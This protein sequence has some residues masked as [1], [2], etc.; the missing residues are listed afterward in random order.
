M[1]GWALVHLSVEIRL[2]TR[3][4]QSLRCQVPSPQ[5][6]ELK[7]CRKSP[8]TCCLKP[9]ITDACLQHELVMASRG[10]L[11]QH[12]SPFIEGLSRD[13]GPG[14]LKSAGS[15]PSRGWGLSPG[16]FEGWQ[17]S[18]KEVP[19]PRLKVWY[20]HSILRRH[21]AYHGSVVQKKSNHN[22]ET[23]SEA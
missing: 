9:T 11:I 4:R 12:A 22:L 6:P 16:T 5:A 18:G 17:R 21:A 15:A 14:T 10:R 2:D 19:T 13:P 3:T 20:S 1:T 23:K 8:A 7:T